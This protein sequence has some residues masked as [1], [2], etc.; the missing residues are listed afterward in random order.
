MTIDWDALHDDLD[1][2]VQDLRDD[3]EE[4]MSKDDSSAV[5]DAYDNA[6]GDLPGIEALEEGEDDA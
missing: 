3:I 4:A 1:D 6:D 2:R 5:Q